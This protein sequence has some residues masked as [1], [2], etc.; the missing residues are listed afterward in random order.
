MNR[1]RST[2]LV[3]AL[4]S[5]G[6]AGG[7]GVQLL[8]QGPVHAATAQPAAVAPRPPAGLPDF[9]QVAREQGPAVV[10]IAVTGS[11][12][13]AAAGPGQGDDPM[14]FFRRFGP[15]IPGLPGI[16][17]GA[18]P[19]AP[20]RGNGSG[21]IISEDG[22]I[23]T[24]AHVVKGASEVTVKLT[25]RREF[26][27]KV[28]G[29]DDKTDVAVLKIDGKGLP[30]ARL[31]SN[32]DLNVGEWVL[33]MGSPFGFENTVTAGVVSNKSR[34]LPDGSGVSF[35][36][37]D[38]AINPGN[39][40]GPLFNARGEVVGINSQIYSRTGGYQGVS[41]AIP[42]DLAVRIKDQIVATGTVKHAR[43]GVVVQDVNQGLAD[44]FGLPRPEGALVS[45]VEPSGPAAQ[46]GLKAGDVVQS[47]DGQRVVASADLP[48]Y[49]VQRAPGDTV[50]L[51]V[52]R[53]GKPV[54]LQARLAGADAGAATAQ[55]PVEAA[56]GGRLGLA[57]RPLQEQEKQ[58]PGLAAGGVR[59]EQASGP[60]A[61]AGVR[62]GDVI[63]AVNGTPVDSVEAVRAATDK[64]GKRVALL[65]QRG[66]VRLFVPVQAG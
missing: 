54:E 43:L 31:G 1:F 28:L 66:E 24:N 32:R 36:Q 58:Q 2:P 9:A 33:A 40:G 22:L 12:R 45:R 60:A 50:K 59:V 38:V 64:A 5:A 42:I 8:H 11:R 18:V 13:T 62:A 56:Q 46:A 21:F 48:A 4:L 55:A 44:S 25:D 34:A 37:T 47:V 52:W 7:V 17:G 39:S 65:V 61:K 30:V 41:F 14:E 10:N 19:E 6:V 35:V 15:G 3:L 26:T 53:A 51:Q 27:A 23:L 57:V 16:P 20:V 63:V 49:L 29:S